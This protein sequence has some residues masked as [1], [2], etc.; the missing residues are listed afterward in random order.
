MSLQHL[1]DFI[2]FDER[3]L[4]QVCLSES[5]NIMLTREFFSITKIIMKC[6]I[7][8]LMQITGEIENCSVAICKKNPN[9][10][11]HFSDNTFIRRCVVECL[12]CTF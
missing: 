3:L 12:P 10:Q 5:V 2:S 11:N 6:R 7:V 1:S 4:I 8:F 9:Q